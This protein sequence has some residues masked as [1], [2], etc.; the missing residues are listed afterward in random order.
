MIHKSSGKKAEALT[1]PTSMEA[2]TP[3]TSTSMP[4]TRRVGL[5]PGRQRMWAMIAEAAL[6]PATKIRTVAVRTKL[7]RSGGW[8][9]QSM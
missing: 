4:N 2:P 9:A 3:P 8:G 6:I 1:P 5:T 7:H